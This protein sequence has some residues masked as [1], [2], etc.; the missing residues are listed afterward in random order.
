MTIAGATTAMHRSFLALAAVAALTFAA[1]GGTASPS[2]AAVATSVPT[3]AP[4]PTPAPRLAEVAVKAQ[5]AAF[6]VAE[7]IDGGLTRVTFE[8]TG[9]APH[10]VVFGRIKEGKTGD[11]VKAAVPKGPPGLIPLLDFYGGAILTPPGGRRQFVLDLDPGEHVLLST[12]AGADGKPDFAK[13]LLK[14]VSVGTRPVAAPPEPEAASILSM[15]DGAPITISGAL[16]TGSQ[17]LKVVVSG[18]A[19]HTL[20]VA[21]LAAGKT[22]ADLEAWLKSRSGPPPAEFVAGM[23]TLSSGR[24]AWALLDLAPGDYLAIDSLGAPSDSQP[25]AFAIR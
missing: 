16:R 13:G 8:N 23:H 22:A 4:T 19:P 24:R 5:D 9:Q 12:N 15:P 17:T 21:K 1:C 3:A 25:Y 10:N 20:V 11:D 6:E 2:P 7:R 18:K 14:L